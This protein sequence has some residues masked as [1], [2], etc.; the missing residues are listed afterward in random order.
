VEVFEVSSM[1]KKG[2]RGGFKEIKAVGIEWQDH[3]LQTREQA[4][5]GLRLFSYHAVMQRD[6]SPTKGL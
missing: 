4:V 1:P 2:A 5:R 3:C 6:L